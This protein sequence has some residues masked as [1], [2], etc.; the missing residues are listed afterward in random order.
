MAFD[1]TAPTN[2]T[3]LSEIT[4]GYRQTDIQWT[5]DAT[6]GHWLRAEDGQPHLD[7]AINQQISAANVLVLEADHI[8]QPYPSDG[9]W[10][11]GNFAYATPLLGQGRVFLFRDG[12]YIE[13]L[14]KRDDRSQPLRY[15]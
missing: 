4:V 12:E 10:G 1:A 3:A 7:A 13:G 2:G 6:S 8:E 14:W 5:Y 11:P 9:Y 15:T